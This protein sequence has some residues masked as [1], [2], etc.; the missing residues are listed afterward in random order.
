MECVQ[1][2]WSLKI[3]AGI[4]GGHLHISSA[5]DQ[6]E[7]EQEQAGQRGQEQSLMNTFKVN[8]L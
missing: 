7:Q 8:L 5:N 4:R 3:L 1:E 2:H 6:E